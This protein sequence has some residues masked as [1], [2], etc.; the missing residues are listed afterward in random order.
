M[1][2]FHTKENGDRTAELEPGQIMISGTDDIIDVI[3]EASL[4]D[5]GKLIVH[6]GS[7]NPD[8]FDLSTG[9]AGEIL[10]KFSNYRMKLAIIGDFSVY[11]SKS[12]RDFIRESNRTGVI[13]FKATLED[14]LG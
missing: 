10:Q 9:L 3:A 8:F 13:T 11:K 12:L 6:S 5:C 4:N 7:L 2:R 1:L 14:A